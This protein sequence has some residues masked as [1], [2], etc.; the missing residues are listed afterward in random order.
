M[1]LGDISHKPFAEI[2]EMCKNYSRSR[3]KTGKNV[4]DPYN[5][6]L[7]LVS[8]GGIM[9]VEIGNLLENFKTGS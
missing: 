1:A 6:S 4:W 2:C 3:A 9:R 5:K 7:K 8:L